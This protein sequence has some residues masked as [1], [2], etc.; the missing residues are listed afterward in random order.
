MY[1]RRSPTDVLQPLAERGTAPR[2]HLLFSSTCHQNKFRRKLHPRLDDENDG[3][4]KALAW[5]LGAALRDSV[6]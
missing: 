6:G 2:C 4:G 5:I 1:Q 3:R